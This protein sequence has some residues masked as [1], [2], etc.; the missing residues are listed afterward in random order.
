[1]RREK[2]VWLFTIVLLLYSASLAFASI[3]IFSLPEMPPP[4]P[5]FSS[6]LTSQHV[7]TEVVT[8]P[9]NELKSAGSRYLLEYK[10]WRHI[11]ASA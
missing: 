2:K 7:I 6:R 9:R 11:Q 1:M 10:T 4:L 5:R 8:P 3:A